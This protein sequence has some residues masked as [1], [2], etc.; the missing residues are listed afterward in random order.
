VAPGPRDIW[1]WMI[2]VLDDV[3]V[4]KFWYRLRRGDVRGAVRSI[5]ELFTG[6]PGCWLGILGLVALG[7][8]FARAL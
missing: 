6:F 4:E 5:G 8:L 7:V 1:L 3:V 2:T